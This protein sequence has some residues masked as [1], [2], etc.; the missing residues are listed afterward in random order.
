VSDKSV[1]IPPELEDVASQVGEFIEYWGF[2]NVHG[3]IWT[4]LFLAEEPL[5]AGELIERLGISKALVSMSISDLME[6]EV[7]QVAGKSPRGTVTYKSNPDITTVISNVLRKRERRMLG[8]ISSAVRL[9]REL[10][11]ESHG[12]VKLAPNRIAI[13]TDMVQA[14]EQT[15]DGVLQFSDVSMDLWKAFDHIPE[16]KKS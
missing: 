9:L 12:G 4:H 1:R 6:Y 5:D 13:I 15:L 11:K 14:A 16:P 2:K 3:R 10:P 8:R 7:I